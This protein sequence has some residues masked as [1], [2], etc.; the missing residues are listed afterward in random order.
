MK[1]QVTS[2]CVGPCAQGFFCP[3][4]T[5]FP[6]TPPSQLCPPGLRLC[7][8][9]AH[10]LCLAGRYG[11]RTGLTSSACAGICPSGSWCPAGTITPISCGQS[12][13]YCVRPLFFA[14]FTFSFVRSRATRRSLSF[15]LTVTTLQEGATSNTTRL[16]CRVLRVTLVLEESELPARLGAL[17][18]CSP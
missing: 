13:F 11:N 12:I 7:L 4:G 10:V 8:C 6:G 9:L 15:L 16:Q 17:L 1:G 3:A 18:C 2:S 14:V 5:V